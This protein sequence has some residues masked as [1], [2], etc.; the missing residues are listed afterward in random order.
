M[1]ASPGPYSRW[2]E[3]SR[4]IRGHVGH[5]DVLV[6]SARY[7][8][9]HWQAGRAICDALAATSPNVASVELDYMDLVHPAVNRTVQSIY[10]TS[11]KHFPSG[12][13]WFYR[14]TCAIPPDS[15]FQ[16]FLNRLGRENLAALLDEA[17]PKVVVS[18]F[19]TQAGVLSDMRRR[20][21]INIPTITV[22]TDHTV[23]SQ[24][25]HPFTDLYCVSSPEVAQ[26]LMHRG[27][28]AARIV[29][30]GIP[31]RQAFA[32]PIDPRE[33]RK[34]HNL[35]PDLPIILVMSG[36][37]GALGGTVSTCH[38]LTHMGRPLQL[39][40]IA[41]KDRQLAQRLRGLTRSFP[42]PVHIMGFVEEVADFM[43]AADLLITKA[44]GLTTAE[45]AA[46]G[47]PMIIFRPI[48]GQEEANAAYFSERGAALLSHS[49]AELR[50]HVDAVLG[51][52][53]RLAAM[54]RAARLLGRPQAANHVTQLAL[55]LGTLTPRPGRRLPAHEV[56]RI[57]AG[58][59]L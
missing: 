36:A 6:L 51:D 14:T 54:S 7:G 24:W 42:F 5:A 40:V 48:P 26:A 46:V 31:V 28:D 55:A 13:G 35:D 12:Y 8:A 52:R 25:V 38:V 21:R 50:D 15:P 3:R 30:T 19:P 44:G 27:V 59:S 53:E 58:A 57:T 56:S 47:L 16:S 39:V 10:L 11:I 2:T 23:H 4:L 49:T 37:F 17:R 34:R 45:A 20:E 29:V 22:I 43:G 9:G 1:V 33:A 41:G 18:T 32:H